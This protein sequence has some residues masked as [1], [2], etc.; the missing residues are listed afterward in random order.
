MWKR[1]DVILPFLLLSRRFVC[2]LRPPLTTVP[3]LF[4]EREA[5]NSTP[6]GFYQLGQYL[7]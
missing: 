5:L 6:N 3:V 7:P 1:E 2:G 4:R